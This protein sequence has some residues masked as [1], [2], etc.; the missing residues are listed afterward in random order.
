LL[1]SEE[2]IPLDVVPTQHGPAPPIQ[3]LRVVLQLLDGEEEHGCLHLVVLEQLVEVDESDR[4]TSTNS[5]PELILDSDGAEAAPELGEEQRAGCGATCASSEM[6]GSGESGG[7]AVECGGSAGR[8]R[9][10]GCVS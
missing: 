3:P 4:S 2:A 7:A 6:W 8:E 9:A 1:V 5:S 10:S